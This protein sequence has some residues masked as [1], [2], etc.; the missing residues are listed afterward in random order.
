MIHKYWLHADLMSRMPVIDVD[1][2]VVKSEFGFGLQA[3]RDFLNGDPTGNS[4][5]SII[6]SHSLHFVFVLFTL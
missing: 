6:N 3:L 5:T 2:R 1:Y 4:F